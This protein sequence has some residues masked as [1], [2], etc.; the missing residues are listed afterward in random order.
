MATPKKRPANPV[1]QS[2][3]AERTARRSLSSGPAGRLAMAVVESQGYLLGTLADPVRQP[4]AHTPQQQA[5][6]VL[7]SRAYKLARCAYLALS[8]GY[9][10]SS[11]PTIRALYERLAFAMHAR[12]DEQFAKDLVARRLKP[13]D[14][15]KYATRAKE[16]FPSLLEVFLRIRRD[17]SVRQTD[18]D[19][20]E[21]EIARLYGLL[22]DLSHPGKDVVPLYFLVDP[23]TGKALFKFLPDVR[24]TPVSALLLLLLWVLQFMFVLLLLVEFSREDDE[25]WKRVVSSWEKSVDIFVA[26][27]IPTVN[28]EVEAFT[29]QMSSKGYQSP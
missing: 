26:Q 19:N 13:T 18:M 3:D 17:R 12:S 28:E 10:L 14:V 2:M 9:P 11:V 23:S 8:S 1:K 15:Q 20:W 22:S 29:R 6:L 21:R 7:G 24:A 5:I 16:G 27:V 4:G 25:D